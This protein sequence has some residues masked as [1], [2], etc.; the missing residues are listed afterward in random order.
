MKERERNGWLECFSGNLIEALSSVRTVRGEAC[1]L[2]SF[3]LLDE[4]FVKLRNSLPKGKIGRDGRMGLKIAEV[5]ELMGSAA[6]KGRLRRLP[7]F[8]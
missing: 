6:A 7:L 1:S 2:G 4:N 8:V 3:R 5:S